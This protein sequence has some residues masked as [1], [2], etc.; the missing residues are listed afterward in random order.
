MKRTKQE[1]TELE[2][3]LAEGVAEATT[4][5]Q[6]EGFAAAYALIDYYAAE[7]RQSSDDIKTAKIWLR[8]IL[9]NLQLKYPSD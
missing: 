6:V 7:A 2:L 1:I 9:E 3:A 5:T 8:E 4:P